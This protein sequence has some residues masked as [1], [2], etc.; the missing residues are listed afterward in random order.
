MYVPMQIASY[1]GEDVY[2]QSTTRSPIY[3]A[4][5]TGYTITEKIAFECPENNGVEN[6]LYNVQSHPYSE[7]F[8]VVE[9]IANKEVIARVVH[10]LQS[11]S[12][13]NIYVICMHELEG[14]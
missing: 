5:D 14:E 7:L 4:H 3:C 12:D 1:L 2:I 11:V 9:R 8:L 13:A 6:Y 10:A